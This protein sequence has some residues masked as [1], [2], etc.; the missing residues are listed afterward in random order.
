[1]FDPEILQ[2]STAA[3][4]SAA[5]VTV[6]LTVAAAV[7]SLLAGRASAAL[8]I[9][10]GRIGYAVSRTYV[11]VMRGTPLFVQLLVVFFGLPLL[12]LRGQA[13]LAAVLA[14]GLNSGAYTTEILRAAIL[15]VPRGQVEAAD[16]VGMS[17]LAVWTR[18][19]LPQAGIISIPMLTAELTIV[20]KSTPLAS[21]ISVTEM[22]YTGVLIQSRA[23]TAIEVFAPIAIGYI[24]IAQAFMRAS[25]Y[26]ERRL[27]PLRG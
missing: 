27:Q 13:F 20:L 3:I 4:A 12:G 22:T 21:V 7:V 25:R 19:V 1:M 16:A 17:R 15:A 18:I 24:L 8:Q 23:F 10:G 5:V 9:G 14:I 6:Q 26:F 11:S 2:Q